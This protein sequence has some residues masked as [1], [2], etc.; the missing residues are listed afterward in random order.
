[1]QDAQFQKRADEWAAKD[2]KI[3]DAMSRM[4][5]TVLKKNNLKEKEAERR[6]VAYAMEKDQREAEKERTKKEQARLRD[7]E[8]L[9][10][11]DLQVDEKKKI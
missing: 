5:D 9:R 8:V 11:L 3:K 7:L 4:A 10:T 6:A 1:M 2:Q